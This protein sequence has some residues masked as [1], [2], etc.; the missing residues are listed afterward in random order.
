MRE[1]AKAFYESPAWRRTREYIL[2]RDAG[3]CVHCGEPGVIVHH[4]IELTPRNIDDPAIALGEDNLE[5][6]CRTCHAL[7]HEGTPPLA[8]VSNRASILGRTDPGAHMRGG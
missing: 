8:P 4:K 7:I 3:L 1:F 5:T 2:K 6:V